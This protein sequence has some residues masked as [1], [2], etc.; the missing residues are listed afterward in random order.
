[1]FQISIKKLTN[2]PLVYEAIKSTV[3]K[4]VLP[5]STLFDIYGWEHSITRTQMF[6]IEMKNIHSFCSVHL[7]RHKIGVEHFV[8]SNRIDRGG[9]EKADRYTPVKHSM[10]INAEA[11]IAIA[12]ARLCFKAS[13]ETREIIYSV[14][15]EMIEIDFALAL[16]M[17]PKCF[18]QGMICK[19]PKPCGRYPVTRWKNYIQSLPEV[20]I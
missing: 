18:H 15:K 10:L 6:W 5:K 13:K 20:I 2:V 3:N 16:H 7:V 8:Q 17:L 4:D 1:M 11:V 12:K 19:E 14:K 9:K